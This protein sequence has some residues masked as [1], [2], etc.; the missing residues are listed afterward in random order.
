[1]PNLSEQKKAVEELEAL[2]DDFA[3]DFPEV[4]TERFDDANDEGG[5]ESEDYQKLQDDVAELREIIV[6]KLERLRSIH[7]R[8]V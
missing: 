6:K 2:L 3:A 4:S 8:L 1:M 5:E 7:N